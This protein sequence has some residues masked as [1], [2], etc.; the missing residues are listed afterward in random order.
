MEAISYMT[1]EQYDLLGRVNFSTV[2]HLGRSP[3]HYRHNLFHE[4]KD[5]DAMKRGR[6]LSIAVFEPDEY[7][8]QVAIWD[9]GRRSG[10]E[11]EAFR[12]ANPGRELLKV[13]EEA[14]VQ[15]MATAVRNHPMAAKYVTGGRGEQTVLWTDKESG[16]DCKARLDF[17]AN[18]GALVDLKSSRDASPSG[19][20]R[21]AWNLCYHAQAAF[22]SDAYFAVTGERLPF[23]L[24][25]VEA[26]APHV[27][28][29]YRV[30]ERVLE[31]GRDYYRGLL[32]RLKDCRAEASWP[33]YAEQELEL[34]LPRWATGIYPDEDIG[35]LGLVM[36]GQENADGL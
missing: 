14:L 3:A 21:Q 8:R 30:P 24:A 20:G 35:E 22:Y 29:V 9:G 25:A 16:F 36:E 28:Q 1:R 18:A 17:I 2:K 31:L 4:R 7:R 26:E 12:K 23:V 19:F 32:V 15:S 5:T 10:K 27:V 11:W 34:E 13:E 6:A 33:G